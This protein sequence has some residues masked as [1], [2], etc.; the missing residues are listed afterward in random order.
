MSEVSSQIISIAIKSRVAQIGI[1]PHESYPIRGTL[2]LLGKKLM[3]ACLARED[4]PGR[5]PVDQELEVLLLRKQGQINQG[6]LWICH[7]SFEQV[8]PVTKQ[9]PDRLCLKK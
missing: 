1:L 2:C 8:L 6:S 9:A 4:R 3:D 5:I 7:N